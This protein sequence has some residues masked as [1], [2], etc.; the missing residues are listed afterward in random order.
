MIKCNKNRIES[1]KTLLF[2]HFLSFYKEGVP[3]ILNLSCFFFWIVKKS[4]NMVFWGLKKSVVFSLLLIY[5]ICLNWVSVQI[6]K[7]YPCSNNTCFYSINIFI[8]NCVL[9]DLK[10]NKSKYILLKL[11]HSTCLKQRTQQ[12]RIFLT[13]ITTKTW[14]IHYL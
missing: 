12:N 6:V 11:Y 1:D 10:K 14:G 4:K 8:A 13:H 3:I 2:Y 7:I 5:H 9:W